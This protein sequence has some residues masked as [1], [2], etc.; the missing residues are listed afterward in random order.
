MLCSMK[1][2]YIAIFLLLAIGCAKKT[3]SPIVG[4]WQ[5]TS[6]SQFSR[7]GG[8]KMTFIFSEDG[9][10]YSGRLFPDGTEYKGGNEI[11]YLVNGDTI[12]YTQTPDGSKW[13]DRFVI[14]DNTLTLTTIEA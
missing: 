3:S 13:K 7:D 14:S 10:L 8:I 6:M 1:L 4:K 2:I 9:R 12:S 5:T 11:R